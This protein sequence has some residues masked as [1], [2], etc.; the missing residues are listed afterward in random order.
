MREARL[1]KGFQ[2]TDIGKEI[3]IRHVC[4]GVLSKYKIKITMRCFIVA[5]VTLVASVTLVVTSF[6]GTLAEA[7][8]HSSPRSPSRKSLKSYTAGKTENI[9]FPNYACVS[10]CLK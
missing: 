6:G 5:P 7:A 4:R 2:I 9:K 10:E 1:L 3:P 8:A